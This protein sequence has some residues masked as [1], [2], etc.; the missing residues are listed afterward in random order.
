MRLCRL[1]KRLFPGDQDICPD[2]ATQTVATALEP[3]PSELLAR[4]PEPEPLAQGATGTLYLVDRPAG[5]EAQLGPKLVLKV[6]A[7]ELCQDAGERTRHRRDLRK[8][9]GLVHPQL[10]RISEEGEAGGRVWFTREYVPA[11]SLAVRLH[12]HGAFEPGAAL[13]MIVQLAAALDGLHQLGLVHRDLKPGHVLLRAAQSGSDGRVSVQLIDATFAAP[14][15]ADNPAR[16]GSANYAAKEIVDGMSGTVRSDLYALGCLSYELITG[17]PPFRGASALADG[18]SETE[19]TLAAQRDAEPKEL[20]GNVP[21]AVRSVIASLLSK[22]AHRRPFSAQQVRRSIEPFLSPAK[23][24][25][26]SEPRSVLQ[27]EAAALRLTGPTAK[28]V[29]PRNIPDAT[30]ELDVEELEE[31]IEAGA[32]PESEGAA[33]AVHAANAAKAKSAVDDS[34]PT[35][36]LDPARSAN[37]APQPKAAAPSQIT[38]TQ[39]ADKS[40]TITTARE[41]EQTATGLGSEPRATNKPSHNATDP[42]TYATKP[43]PARASER[44]AADGGDAPRAGAAPSDAE[45]AAADGVECAR[46]ST[47]AEERSAGEGAASA[48]AE[49]SAAGGVDVPGADGAV[50]AAA[51]VEDGPRRARTGTK[52]GLGPV[53]TTDI[54]AAALAAQVSAVDASAALEVDAATRSAYPPVAEPEAAPKVHTQAE[55]RSAYSPVPPAHPAATPSARPKRYSASPKV[56]MQSPRLLLWA[57]GGLV[58][59]LSVLRLAVGPAAPSRSPS[60]IVRVPEVAT[61]LPAPKQTF[62]ELSEHALIGGNIAGVPRAPLPAATRAPARQEPQQQAADDDGTG[63]DALAESEL[64]PDAPSKTVRTVSAVSVRGALAR[65]ASNRQAAAESGVPGSENP[66]PVDFKAKGRELYQAGKYREAADA[67]QRA[68]QRNASDAAA[69]AG[70]GGSL[71]A[72]GDTS[73]AIAAYQRAVRLEPAV[74]GFQAALGRAYLKKGDRTRAKAAYSKALKLDPNNQAARSGMANAKA[75]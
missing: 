27:R 7:A 24:L 21:L 70:L 39:P 10:P 47:G 62:A 59:L 22:D 43:Q 69:F 68:T 53:R 45:S 54:E 3:L 25:P 12:K 6:L 36:A 46:I 5:I 11:T 30:V 31:A 4:F 74:S 9:Q 71:L 37:L 2:D 38:L 14:L 65:A 60:V 28:P 33:P 42:L 13:V 48:P 8:Q 32:Q 63:G 75:R 20:P 57:A 49:R 66:A 15:T 51:S 1:C 44:L 18:Q 73:K 58:V 72:S 55:V 16:R 19:A 29:T 26:R 52:F 17:V 23:P 40:A 41:R 64:D 56:L 34:A 61:E 35:I 67:Y 50:S